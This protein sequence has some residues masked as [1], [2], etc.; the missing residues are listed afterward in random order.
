MPG[1]ACG[2]RKNGLIGP[3]AQYDREL[4]YRLGGNP[5]RATLEPFLGFVLTRAIP[6]AVRNRVTGR[7]ES[8]LK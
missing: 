7:L 3:V 4:A 8:S 2:W 6:A 5:Y 1:R